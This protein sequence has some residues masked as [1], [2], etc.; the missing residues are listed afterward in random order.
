MTAIDNYNFSIKGIASL[1]FNRDS[2]GFEFKQG[3]VELGFIR[4]EH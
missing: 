1:N 3:D 2:S 4:K